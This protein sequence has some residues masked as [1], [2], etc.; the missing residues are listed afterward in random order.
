MYSSTATLHHELDG[1]IGLYRAGFL[2]PRML[3]LDVNYDVLFR[4]T[5]ITPIRDMALEELQSRYLLL[6]L[7]N[8]SIQLLDVVDRASV[9]GQESHRIIGI[10]GKSS[11]QAR[12]SRPKVSDLRP[13]V[14][15][16]WYPVDS[17][18]FF[19]ASL[20]R[21]VKIWD[22]NRLTC[23]DSIELP[24]S[25]SWIALSPCAIRHN[26]VAV[27]LG[28]D[29]SAR[30]VLLDPVIGA[31]AITLIGGHSPAGLSSIVWSPRSSD[32]LVT[33]GHDG[34]IL[35]WDIR[36]PT[37][38]VHSLDRYGTHED[39]GFTPDA[40]AHTGSVLS[41]AFTPDGLHLFSWGGA[42][43]NEDTLCLRMWSAGPDEAGLKVVTNNTNLPGRPLLR[44]V[45]FGTVYADSG[46]SRDWN[47]SSDLG[48][49]IG[50]I[51]GVEIRSQS[52][53]AS[54]A[55]WLSKRRIYAASRMAV[56]SGPPGEAWG[57]ESAF[58][59]VP[60]R[61]RLFMAF[62]AKRKAQTQLVN[63][64]Y[65]KIRACIWNCEMRELY[66]CGM[67]GNLFTW[68]FDPNVQDPSA[69]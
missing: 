67:D 14:C 64:H 68:Q 11:E 29:E 55:P 26:L 47:T 54:G 15:I 25:I 31:A 7:Q 22:T 41:L 2:S 36:L 34:R 49:A 62:A 45:N 53:T 17:G 18:L 19:T 21:T 44:P 35:F 56:V 33:A 69:L 65:D 30:S 61:S 48:T 9:D 12:S 4:P 13:V 66:T 5:A 43:T 38:P 32:T 23:A 50:R 20:D 8:G 28:A 6:G 16:Q 24:S 63:R 3:Q 1:R 46:G 39:D 59:Y 42:G 57:A 60:H 51:T 58:V 37:K 10:I 27:A 40:A 52:R